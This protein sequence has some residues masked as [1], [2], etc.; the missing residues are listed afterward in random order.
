MDPS[1]ERSQVLVALEESVCADPNIV[2][3]VVFGSQLSDEATQSSDLDLAVK[4]VNELSEQER[5]E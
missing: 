2:F 1:V 5:F 3:A 4:F